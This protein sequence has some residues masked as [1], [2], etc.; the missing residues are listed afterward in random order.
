[1]SEPMITLTWEKEKAEGLDQGM[2]Q[3]RKGSQMREMFFR[4]SR[5]QEMGMGSSVYGR[6]MKMV[7]QDKGHNVTWAE[8]RGEKKRKNSLKT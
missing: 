8:G 3:S 2:T 7:S 4:K 6:N 1:M 5:G